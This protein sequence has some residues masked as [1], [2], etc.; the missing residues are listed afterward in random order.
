MRKR[1]T[2]LAVSLAMVTA[3]CASP[4]PASDK[5]F[6]YRTDGTVTVG[7]R[8]A[9]PGGFFGWENTDITDCEVVVLEGP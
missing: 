5:E 9:N 7:W 3:A 1:L 6:E 4:Q 8:C 2:L